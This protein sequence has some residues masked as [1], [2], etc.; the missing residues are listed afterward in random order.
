VEPVIGPAT[1]GRTRWLATSP[2]WGEVKMDSRSRSASS[3]PKPWHL[4]HLNPH[5][6]FHAVLHTKLQQANA[7]G[8][9]RKRRFG[10]DDGTNG[11]KRFGSET[12][13]DADWY[14]ALASGHGRAWSARR[15]SIGVPP[16]RLVP[17]SLSSQ[18][19]QLQ[20]RLPGTWRGHVLRIPLSGRYPPLPVPVQRASRTP[21]RSARGLMPKAARARVASPPPGAA[22]V[23]AV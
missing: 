10:M 2:H 20:A 23:R 18:G 3:R 14:S 6:R 9:I 17:R 21:S 4:T 16:R 22:L 13:T 11:R 7:G 8:S 5:H 12:P 15:T 19:T 1:S